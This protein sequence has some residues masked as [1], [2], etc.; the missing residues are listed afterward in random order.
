MS[1]FKRLFGPRHPISDPSTQARAP[2]FIVGLGNPGHR[3]TLTRH[4]FGWLAL[5][6]LREVWHGS[7]WHTEKKFQA[8]TSEVQYEGK[9][10]WLVKPQTFMNASGASVRA[11][12]DF[13]HASPAQLIVLHDEVDIPF[14]KIKT[15]TS[16]RAAGHNGVQDIIDKLRTQDFRRLRLGVGKPA[17]PNISVA[18]HVLQPFTDLELAA[19]PTYLA[20]AKSKL[21][22]DLLL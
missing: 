6:S 19:L 15:T 14:G 16:S 1:F 22:T 13:Y 11:I 18:D 9:K 17:N 2:L 5:E 20:E 4:N 12:L 21:E 7:E 8:E 10:I 3:Y